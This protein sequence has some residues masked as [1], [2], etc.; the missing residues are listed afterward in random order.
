MDTQRF[1]HAMGPQDWGDERL[2]RAI[3]LSESGDDEG[4]LRVVE[5]I[6]KGTQDPD[7]LAVLAVGETR[8]LLQLG[9]FA[10]AENIVQSASKLQEDNSVALLSLAIIQ[11]HAGELQNAIDTLSAAIKQ[12]PSN[13][14]M[15]SFLGTEELMRRSLQNRTS[16][17]VAWLLGRPWSPCPKA[18]R[19]C[20]AYRWPGSPRWFCPD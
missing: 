1:S 4:A 3:A 20:S 16:I 13:S 17:P 10:E 19:R 9:R 15:L 2:L 11:T 6:R 12:Y 5:D 7:R 8:F 14:Q 18:S